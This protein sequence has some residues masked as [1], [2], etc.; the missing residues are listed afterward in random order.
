LIDAPFADTQPWMSRQ[1]IHAR[2]DNPALTWFGRSMEFPAFPEA[3]RR[4]RVHASHQDP[5]SAVPQYRRKT[6]R[7]I[8]ADS[9]SE[10]GLCNR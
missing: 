7:E 8:Q 1:L 2:N 10:S 3:R 4:N 6:F 5:V 9:G